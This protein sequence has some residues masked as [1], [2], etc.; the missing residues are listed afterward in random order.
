MIKTAN[1]SANELKCQLLF[2]NRR[3]NIEIKQTMLAPL[4]ISFTIISEAIS[5][6]AF[7]FLLAIAIVGIV[8]KM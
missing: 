7:A 4:L 2:F 5:I 6:I 8:N 1:C 3:K